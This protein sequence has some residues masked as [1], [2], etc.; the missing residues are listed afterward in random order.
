MGALNYKRSMAAF[1]KFDAIL[2]GQIGMDKVEVSSRDVEIVR[3]AVLSVLGKP[4]AANPN[5]DAYALDNF[6]AFARRKTQIVLDLVELN[7]MKDRRLV[8]FVMH[9]I[10]EQ[11]AEDIS[12]D[13][14]NTLKPLIFELFPKLQL[15]SIITTDNYYYALNLLSIITA[16][17]LRSL[18]HIIDEAVLP[19]SLKSLVIKDGMGKWLHSVWNEEIEQL[20]AQ[21]GLHIELQRNKGSGSNEDWI[22]ITL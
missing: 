3:S 15:L 13:N 1:W 18:L 5:I 21:K 22:V 2:S 16:F 10:K 8:D 14:T 9:P 4:F 7:K 17:N 12:E 6:F 19:S 20:Y 11:R